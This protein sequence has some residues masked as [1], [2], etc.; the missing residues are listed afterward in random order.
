MEGP[1]ALVEVLWNGTDELIVRMQEILSQIGFLRVMAKGERAGSQ[2]AAAVG[3][4]K[5]GSGV[6]CQRFGRFRTTRRGGGVARTQHFTRKVGETRRWR[7]VVRS[8]CSALRQ[9]NHRKAYCFGGICS[10]DISGSYSR[11]YIGC[12]YAAPKLGKSNG[13]EKQIWGCEV[14]NERTSKRSTQHTGKE[15]KTFG[16]V[17]RLHRI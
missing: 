9:V 1:R 16:D 17:A 4:T 11:Q 13:D 2:R 14:G 10:P 15:R 3:T 8:R 7:S 6:R 5:K 12:G